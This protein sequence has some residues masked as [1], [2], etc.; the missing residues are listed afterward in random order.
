MEAGELAPDSLSLAVGDVDAAEG[1]VDND[2]AESSST[3]LLLLPPLL[4]P[5]VLS[6]TAAAAAAAEAPEELEPEAAAES[7]PKNRF[8]GLAGKS[9]MLACGGFGN[10]PVALPCR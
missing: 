4:I 10:R 2:F 8:T 9:F 5:A 3:R 7:T 6:P 1:D